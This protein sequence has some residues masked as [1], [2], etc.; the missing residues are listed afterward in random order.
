[1]IRLQRKNQGG[2]QYENGQN[3]G[4]DARQYPASH[5]AFQH[6]ADYR[7]HL[8]AAIFHGRHHYRRA[9]HRRKC[10]GGGRCKRVFGVLCD[11]LCHGA[12]RRLCHHG[13]T[14]VRRRGHAGRAAQHCHGCHAL[15]GLFRPFDG[16]QYSGDARPACFNEYAAGGH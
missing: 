12:C 16:G 1:M 5:S 4:Y 13:I 3:G 2:V 15:R 14:A 6:S 10:A 7:K 8:S 9:D 11:R